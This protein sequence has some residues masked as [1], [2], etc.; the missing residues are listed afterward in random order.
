MLFGVLISGPKRAAGAGEGKGRG[1]A[2]SGVIGTALGWVVDPSLLGWG[3]W[4]HV[5]L[6]SQ[7][8]GDRAFCGAE[9]TPGGFFS[10]H[11]P[12]ME[13]NFESS[14]VRALQGWVCWGAAS[15]LGPAPS[16]SPR[17][18]AVGHELVPLWGGPRLAPT[19]RQVQAAQKPP[20]LLGKGRGRR[21]GLVLG[22]GLGGGCRGDRRW[23]RGTNR[24]L[25]PQNPSA[26]PRGD[27]GRGMAPWCHLAAGTMNWGCS[28]GP[29]PQLGGYRP[30]TRGCS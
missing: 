8:A 6:L 14:A 9:T 2:G 11:Y 29:T 25:T 7:D 20:R 28:G 13:E 21:P 30:L 3:L 1:A 19:L 26:H 22:Q 18:W 4:L 23:H 12:Q 10:C 16:P 17:A 15:P 27:G 5:S 24:E